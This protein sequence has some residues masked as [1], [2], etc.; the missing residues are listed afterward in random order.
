MKFKPVIMKLFLPVIFFLTTSNAAFSQ[1]TI[2]QT[3]PNGL[4]QGYWVMRYPSGIKKYE[5]Y[6]ENGKPTGKLTRYYE[7][8]VKKVLMDYQP[9]GKT[10][11]AT[12][13]YN[14]G[15]KA[16][17]GKYVSTKK[18]STWNYY[19]Y[20]SEKLRS[21]EF[22]D[23]GAKEGVATKYYEDGTISEELEFMDDMQHGTWKQYYENEEVR[24]EGFFEMGNRTGE[25]KT[26]YPSGKIE[27]TGFFLDNLMH[28]TW[29]YF[30][31]EGEVEMEI[32]YNKGIPE[33]PEILNEQQKEFFEKIEENKGKI[34]EPDINDLVPGQ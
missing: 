6:F 27:T 5:G 11:Y 33:N 24:L 32:K 17:K 16:A 34:P 23:N 28:D 20:Y 13:Y 7:D 30:N 8:G 10:V 22:Y 4:K 12:F 3:G 2:N 31:E 18:D 26:Y 9:D 14:N 15:K 29:T 1:D 25:F 21:K 19:S